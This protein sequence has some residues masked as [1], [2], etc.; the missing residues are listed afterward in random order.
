MKGKKEEQVDRQ[1]DN[2]NK[3]LQN[4]LSKG[5]TNINRTIKQAR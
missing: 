4:T 1:T 2:L 3:D 5:L